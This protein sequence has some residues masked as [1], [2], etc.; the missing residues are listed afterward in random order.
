[1]KALKW[2]LRYAFFAILLG[3]SVALCV[4]CFCVA[5]ELGDKIGDVSFIDL[6]SNSITEAGELIQRQKDFEA[7]GIISIVFAVVFAIA[8]GILIA[9]QVN[10]E[11][12]VSHFENR[13]KK[14]KKAPAPVIPA[15][16]AP[17]VPAAQSINTAPESQKR[18]KAT[19]NVISET[20][21]ITFCPKCSFANEG[22]VA[23]CARCGEKIDG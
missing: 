16:P 11:K 17:A 3:I 8:I 15:S 21:I 10:E 13:P 18:E 5:R 20:R 1:M 12:I 14:E 6:A 19:S 22:D 9:Y 7:L 4:Y 2:F 23:F